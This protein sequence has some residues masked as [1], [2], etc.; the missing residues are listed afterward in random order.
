MMK[1]E[2]NLIKTNL[3][4]VS[5]ESVFLKETRPQPQVHLHNNSKMKNR[6]KSQKV[7]GNFV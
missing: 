1:I 3:E 5:K 2:Q 6:G 4:T 7:K